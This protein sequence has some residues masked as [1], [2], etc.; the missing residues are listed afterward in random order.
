MFP[1]SL[2]SPVMTRGFS[3]VT[4]LCARRTARTDEMQDMRKTGFNKWKLSAVAAAMFGVGFSYYRV[5]MQNFKQE[6]QNEV[7]ALNDILN[8]EKTHSKK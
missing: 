1:S 6:K 5:Q 7:T 3:T 2:L 8:R 4:H